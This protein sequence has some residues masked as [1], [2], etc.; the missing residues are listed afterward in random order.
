VGQPGAG[1]RGGCLVG[2]AGGDQPVFQAR[3][4]PR[5]GG[6]QEPALQQAAGLGQQLGVP[7]RRQP[8]VLGVPGLA[9]GDDAA[10]AQQPG[11]ALRASAR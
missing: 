11:R 3:A 7:A 1:Q 10:V 6:E 2:Q 4:G 5:A 8:R 9:V